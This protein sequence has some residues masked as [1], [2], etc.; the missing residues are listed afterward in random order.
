MNQKLIKYTINYKINSKLLKK[1]RLEKQIWTKM[2]SN[3]IC[4]IR[5]SS[6][7]F[8]KLKV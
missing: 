5:K 7:D 4:M 1:S 3:G 2:H 6:Y 8:F